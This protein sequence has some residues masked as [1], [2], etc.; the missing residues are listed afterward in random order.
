MY[1]NLVD[2]R[3]NFDSMKQRPSTLTSV[4]GPKIPSKEHKNM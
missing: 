2:H 1:G 4:L 3:L